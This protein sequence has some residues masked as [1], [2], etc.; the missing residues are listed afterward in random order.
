[1]MSSRRTCAK[2]ARCSQLGKTPTLV[3]DLKRMLEQLPSTRV[4]MRDRAAL[5]LGFA[6]AFRRSELVSLD[7]ADLDFLSAGLVVTP[8]KSKTDQE[9]ASRRLGIPFGS[10]EATC[11]V[12]AVQAWLETAH[13]FSGA[14]FQS[15]ESFD[16]VQP[17]R[18]SDRAVA[19]IPERLFRCRAWAARPPG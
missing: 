8:R 12:R 6:G 5:L 10:T 2:R 16:R 15:L 14:V 17:E 11:P 18:L 19:R 13:I 4:G 9:G 3:A 1:M 7:V